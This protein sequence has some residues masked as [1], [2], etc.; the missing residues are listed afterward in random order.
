MLMVKFEGSNI[1]IS[2]DILVFGTR[3]PTTGV[4][5]FI[6]YQESGHVGPM[7]DQVLVQGQ[8]NIDNCI[9]MLTKIQTQW[10][11][12]RL[13]NEN[14]WPTAYFP[15]SPIKNNNPLVYLLLPFLPV[16]ALPLTLLPFREIFGSALLL[17]LP[18]LPARWCLRE[19]SLEPSCCWSINSRLVACKRR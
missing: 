17:P 14:P 16:L 10:L 1:A 12:D 8:K 15:C 6:S 9:Y 18:F 2:W 11:E 3:V 13:F 19:S 5:K 7:T 4:L